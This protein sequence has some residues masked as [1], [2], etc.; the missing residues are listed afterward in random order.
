MGGAP[1]VAFFL[2]RENRVHLFRQAVAHPVHIAMGLVTEGLVEKKAPRAF[3][4]NPIGPLGS[5]AFFCLKE[6]FFLVAKGLLDEVEVQLV[7]CCRQD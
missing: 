6:I 1:C 3:L 4:L 2:G 5:A 7:V